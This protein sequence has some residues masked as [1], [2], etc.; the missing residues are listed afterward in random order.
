MEN[1]A[2]VEDPDLDLFRFVDALP[3]VEQSRFLNDPFAPAVDMNDSFSL[4]EEPQDADTKLGDSS[5]HGL[6]IEVQ[7]VASDVLVPTSAPRVSSD[8]SAAPSPRVERQISSQHPSPSSHPPPIG[9]LHHP[10]PPTQAS[11]HPSPIPDRMLANNTGRYLRRRSYS[12]PAVPNTPSKMFQPVYL[13][14]GKNGPIR[15]GETIPQ[16]AYPHGFSPQSNNPALDQFEMGQFRAAPFVMGNIPQDPF[17]QAFPGFLPPQAHYPL[18]WQQQQISMLHQQRELE[19][20]AEPQESHGP[21]QVLMARYGLQNQNDLN[22]LPA[23]GISTVPNGLMRGISIMRDGTPS[24]GSGVSI[25]I[26]NPTQFRL[27]RVRGESGLDSP[28]TVCSD[29]QLL[30]R[31]CSETSLVERSRITLSELLTAAEKLAGMTREGLIGVN[32]PPEMDPT[33]RRVQAYNNKVVTLAASLAQVPLAAHQPRATESNNR[34]SSPAHQN[35]KIPL[36]GSDIRRLS[37]R[38]IDRLLQAYGI[39]I[40]PNLYGCDK[41]KL[42]LQFIGA[43]LQLMHNVLE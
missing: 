28:E 36:C 34:T 37:G 40:A 35:L 17:S 30:K 8:I 11:Q 41:K 38:D 7:A 33:F 5:S 19:R 20:A 32:I 16:Q 12:S 1:P 15:I 26:I 6:G 13:R 14:N 29:V 42:Y 9:I 43:S 31:H 24:N 39:L 22:S 23:N 2:E 4:F 18:E 3:S 27:K 25:P 10:T 21:N